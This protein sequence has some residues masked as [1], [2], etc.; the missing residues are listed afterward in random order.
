MENSWLEGCPGG[1]PVAFPQ[2]NNE[3]RG[4]CG[5]GARRRGPGRG[6]AHKRD[7]GGRADISPEG[8][9]GGHQEILQVD[10]SDVLQG[11]ALLPLG[12]VTLPP[13]P[14]LS[15]FCLILLPFISLS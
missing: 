8:G 3:V 1:L 9:S 10:H 5:E 2:R 12:K 4:D 14:G 7:A 15:H 13:F 6:A 11:V